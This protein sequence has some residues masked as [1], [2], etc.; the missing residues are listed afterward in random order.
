MR[1]AERGGWGGDG[2][3]RDTQQSTFL[4]PGRSF[5]KQLGIFKTTQKMEEFFFFHLFL[6]LPPAPPSLPQ[7]GMGFRAARTGATGVSRAFIIFLSRDNL[8]V[9]GFSWGKGLKKKKS[10]PRA[11]LP[12]RLEGAGVGNLST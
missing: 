3:G 8:Q 7:P 5:G 10:N 4:G 1:S 11:G 9:E 6:S 12:R 2:T